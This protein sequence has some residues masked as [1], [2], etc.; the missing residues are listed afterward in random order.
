M[1]QGQSVINSEGGSTHYHATLEIIPSMRFQYFGSKSKPARFTTEV[2]AAL[3][4]GK[5]L[6][7]GWEP[8]THLVQE[9]W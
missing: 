3:E 7:R 2:K 5:I 4:L 6:S 8:S 9:A 1:E